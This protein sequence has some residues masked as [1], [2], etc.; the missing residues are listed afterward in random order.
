MRTELNSKN[1]RPQYTK[2]NPHHQTPSKNKFVYLLETLHTM[3]KL[4]LCLFA[5]ILLVSYPY[6]KIEIS[7]ELKPYV[8]EYKESLKQAGITYK[9]ATQ[10]V[11]EIKLS[12]LG[13]G[14]LGYYDKDTQTVYVSI[15]VIDNPI[16]TRAIVYHELGHAVGMT[17]SCYSCYHIMSMYA[18]V[19]NINKYYA[20]D[21]FW[22]KVKKLHFDSMKFYLD[23]S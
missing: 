20:D 15:S 3:K 13:E 18:H 5:L 9:A 19:E 6:D 16:L 23:K 10:N 21:S 14:I 8:K 1:S 4:L 2:N 22:D 12:P 7:D 11:E 17:H